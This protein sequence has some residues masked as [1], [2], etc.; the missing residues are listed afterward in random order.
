[1]EFQDK[2][3]GGITNEDYVNLN[4]E[5]CNIFN[6]LTFEKLNSKIVLAFINRLR[7]YLEDKIRGS[8]IIKSYEIL[9]IKKLAD[10]V[11]VYL[12]FEPIN[13]SDKFKICL[14]AEKSSN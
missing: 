14:V 12:S 10:K 5:I 4:K 11:F 9:Q 3:S 2:L 7:Q 8:K 6:R 1:M 13:L